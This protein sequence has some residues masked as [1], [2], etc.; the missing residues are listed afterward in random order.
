MSDNSAVVGAVLY[1]IETFIR[2]VEW[3]VVPANSSATAKKEAK[4]LEECIA[5]LDEPWEDFICEVLSMLIYGYSL[6]EVVLKIRG[7]AT[8]PESRRSLYSDGRYG[9]R[10]FAPRAQTSVDEWDLDEQSNVLGVHQTPPPSYAR[11]YLPMERCMLFRTK[12]RRKNPEGR[13]L[14]RNLYRSWYFVKRLEET[15]AIGISRDL[16]GLPVVEVPALIMSPE[17]TD[18]QRAVRATMEKL[19]SQLHRDEREGVVFPA[20]TGLDG[21]PTGYKLK[22]LNAAGASRVLAD[23]VIRRH[24]QRMLMAL[25]AEFLMLG[26]ERTGSFALASTKTSGF[27][28]TLGGLLSSMAAT[29][30]RTAVRRL[31]DIN[32][33]PVEHRASLVPGDVEKPD[34]KELGSFLT[35]LASVNMI[36]PT[37]EMEQELRA[38]ADMPLDGEPLAQPEFAPKDPLVESSARRS[39]PAKPKPDPVAGPSGGG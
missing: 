22:L 1:A 30:N 9:W 4:F 20:E 26:T 2:R 16:N 28:L 8:G 38:L 36:R 13:S 37:A 35:Q 25:L 6:F 12:S 33:V 5:D 24:E 21:K 39:R 17:A 27:A 32:N 23:P 11:V 31:Y 7:G 3:K 10:S 18:A 29:L 19:V 34:L 15:E 14:L